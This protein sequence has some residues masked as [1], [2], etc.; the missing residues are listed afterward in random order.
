VGDIQ[1]FLDAL[2][3]GGY[4]LTGPRRA[5]AGLIAERNGH[6]SAADLVTDARHDGVEVGR[7]TIFRV[8]ELFAELRVVERI[9]LPSGSHAY[10]GCAPEHHH[11]VVCSR[12]GRSQGVHDLGIGAIADEVARST[13]FHVDGH[14]LE[15]W[16]I[17]PT[18]LLAD[19]SAA[20][21]RFSPPAARLLR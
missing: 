3:R 7:A 16:G 18:C 5:V 12:C 10:V 17:C 21:T 1:P 13:G 8:L 20:P 6:F 14:R 11:H 2:D 15:L 9:D 4:R 19:G